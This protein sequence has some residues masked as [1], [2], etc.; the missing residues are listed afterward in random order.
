MSC[1]FMVGGSFSQYATT[2][3]CSRTLKG[4]YLFG[5]SFLE[6]LTTRLLS[7]SQMSSPGI[8]CLGLQSSLCFCSAS[9]LVWASFRQ[10]IKIS[11]CP[12]R[13]CAQQ[14]SMRDPHFPI[15]TPHGTKLN[16]TRPGLMRWRR[17]Q[18]ESAQHSH[19][20]FVMPDAAELS[21]P[22]L[23]SQNREMHYNR[24]AL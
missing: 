10:G 15:L 20:P 4:P 1:I 11:P 23:L 19:T 8:S 9:S 24:F 21:H 5:K 22:W 17:A 16:R 18:Q 3:M 6:P 13:H 2:P 12:D 7:S 14:V